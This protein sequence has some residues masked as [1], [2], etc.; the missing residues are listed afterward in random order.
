MN[1]IYIY[2]YLQKYIFKK[3]LNFNGS[4]NRYNK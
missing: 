1:N 2:L 3:K 4:L